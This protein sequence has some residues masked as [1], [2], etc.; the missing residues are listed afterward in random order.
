MSR[1]CEAI[2][3]LWIQLNPHAQVHGCEIDAAGTVHLFIL[4]S[5]NKKQHPLELTLGNPARTVIRGLRAALNAEAREKRLSAH[6]SK[7]IADGGN[8][9]KTR[10]NEI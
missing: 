2:E 1:E 7:I 8:D 10:K 9:Q 4:Y 5:R 6:G 3:A